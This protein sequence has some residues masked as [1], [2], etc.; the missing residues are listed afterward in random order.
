MVAAVLTLG[1]IPA[2]AAESS[3]DVLR[4]SGWDRLIGTWV[5]DSGRGGEIQAY[6]A[7]HPLD[8]LGNTHVKMVRLEVEA[9]AL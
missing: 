2:G 1:A 9:H 3:G 8:A 7:G 4:E 6:T 5:G